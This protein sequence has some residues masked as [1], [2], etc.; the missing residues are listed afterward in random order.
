MITS[1]ERVI[2]NRSNKSE[3]EEEISD[4]NIK[5]QQK[6]ELNAEDISSPK[7]LTMADKLLAKF[8]TF[9]RHL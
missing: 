6:Y 5:V 3:I 2:P 7:I 8:K 9:H 1:N 4:E